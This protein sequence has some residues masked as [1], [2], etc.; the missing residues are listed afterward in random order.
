MRISVNQTMRRIE[1][2]NAHKAWL[3]CWCFRAVRPTEYFMS[4][5]QSPAPPCHGP[6]VTCPTMQWAPSHLSHHAVGPDSPSPPCTGL[7]VT[8][9]TMQ[10]APSN[11][12]H[13]VMGPE[14]PAP[15]CTGLLVMPQQN[16]KYPDSAVSQEQVKITCSTDR[17]QTSIVLNSY[18]SCM[19]LSLI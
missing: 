9:P 2:S 8:C 13:H 11:L 7:L 3:E 5:S 18:D 14:S 16:H 1:N 15:S 10:W 19:F 12:S 6:L 17:C 4:G